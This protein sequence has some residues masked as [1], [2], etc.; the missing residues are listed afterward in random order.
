MYPHAKRLAMFCC[1]VFPFVFDQF[2]GNLVE[3]LAEVGSQPHSQ[4]QKQ[5]RNT[6]EPLEEV[7]ELI[8]LILNA[9]P[10]EVRNAVRE[11]YCSQAQTGAGFSL[12]LTISNHPFCF[13]CAS[14]SLRFSC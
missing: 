7:Y 14:V 2:T 11:D 3:A 5:T 6:H 4:K 1:S 12:A 9:L 10:L 8:Q 13:S